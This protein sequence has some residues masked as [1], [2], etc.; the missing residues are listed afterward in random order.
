MHIKFIGIFFLATYIPF[1]YATGDFQGIEYLPIGVIFCFAL[2]WVSTRLFFQKS[3]KKKMILITLWIVMMF[4]ASLASM[5]IKK[6]NRAKEYEAYYAPQTEAWVAQ[7]THEACF[8]DMKTIETVLH[9][10]Y[11]RNNINRLGQVI[12]KCTDKNQGARL[13]ISLRLMQALYIYKWGKTTKQGEALS[14]GFCDLVKKFRAE[15]N[16]AL[17]AL[18][19]KTGLSMECTVTQK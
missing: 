15:K 9:G 5:Y 13:E 12:V 3:K 14:Y 7:M 16:N 18:I 19:E 17:I 11:E 6:Q 2:A 10:A 4:I 1:A 8:G